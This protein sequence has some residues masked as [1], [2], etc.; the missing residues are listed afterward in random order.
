MNH[1]KMIRTV[2]FGI[3]VGAGSLVSMP[4][5]SD[6]VA[7]WLGELNVGQPVTRGGLTV[8]PIHRTLQAEKAPATVTLERALDNGWLKIVERESGSVPEVLITNLSHRLIFIMGGEILTGCKQDRLMGRDILI[9]PHARKVVVPVFCVEAGRWTSSSH[10]FSS[11]KN[12]GTHRLRSMAQESSPEAQYKIWDTVASLNARAGVSSS[13]GAY[14]DAYRDE[15]IKKTVEETEKALELTLRDDTAGV[16]IGIGGRI[17][18]LDIF[19]DPVIFRE[20]WPKIRKS[21]V[22]AGLSEKEEAPVTGKHALSFLTEVA[23]QD[24]TPRRPV[25]IGSEIVSADG[26]L[27]VSALSYQKML[28]HLAA[29]P[30]EESPEWSMKQNSAQDIRQQVQPRR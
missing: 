11:E 30:R 19:A 16:M 29:F 22:F 12:L 2:L 5:S 9:R 23:A 3:L 14:Q 10:E 4:A 20:L 18:S 15:E 27:S 8:F 7:T 13:T 24:Y 21:S 6:E 17:V 25:D 1:G 28:I 26:E